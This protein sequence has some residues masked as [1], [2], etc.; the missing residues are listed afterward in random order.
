MADKH[1][2]CQLKIK[3]VLKHNENGVVCNGGEPVGTPEK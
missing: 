2:Q 1:G 3:S